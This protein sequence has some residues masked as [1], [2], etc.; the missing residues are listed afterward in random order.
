MRY[1]SVVIIS[2]LFSCSNVQENSISPQET[3]N[4]I[5]D[6]AQADDISDFLNVFATN[7]NLDSDTKKHF[8]N[9]ALRYK[10]LLKSIKP[11]QVI[12]SKI[13]NN[14]AVIILH[15]K[16]KDYDPIY[17]VNR[18]SKWLLFPGITRNLTPVFTLSPEETQSFKS[19][20]LWFKSK[21]SQLVESSN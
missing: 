5:I 21:K 14:I 12:E 18:K 11:Q 2:I 10:S 20:E 7:S 9:K 17:F 15:E 6:L 16:G 19:I 1:I 3:L 4:N 13:E 8:S